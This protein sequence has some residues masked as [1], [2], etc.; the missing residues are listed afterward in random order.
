[1]FGSRNWT[2][3]LKNTKSVMLIHMEFRIRLYLLQAKA[4]SALLARSSK[5]IITVDLLQL[6][7]LSSRQISSYKLREH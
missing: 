2:R 4:S 1:M 5:R 3:D 6:S 7:N